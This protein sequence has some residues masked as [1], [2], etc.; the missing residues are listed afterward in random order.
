ML[1]IHGRP[2]RR[3]GP[4]QRVRKRF[5]N[6]LCLHRVDTPLDYKI[7]YDFNKD[8]KVA[9]FKLLRSFE[10]SN[11]DSARVKKHLLG[12]RRDFQ[13]VIALIWNERASLA[14]MTRLDLSLNF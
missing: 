13:T 9:D 10:I 11:C 2:Q 6:K 3:F 14:R 7:F 8:L 1:S 5:C 12:V 4:F